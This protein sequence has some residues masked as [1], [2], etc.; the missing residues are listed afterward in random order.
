M[1]YRWLHSLQSSKDCWLLEAT[2]GFQTFVPQRT[3]KIV[4]A[5][6]AYVGGKQMNS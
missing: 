4:L 1:D 5:I 3:S 2:F 6:L